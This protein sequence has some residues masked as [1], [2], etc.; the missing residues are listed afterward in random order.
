MNTNM[1]GFRWFS[2]ILL[3]CALNENSLSIGKVKPL[4]LIDDVIQYASCIRH[5]PG[6]LLFAIGMF[7]DCIYRG[8]NIHNTSKGEIHIYGVFTCLNLPIAVCALT[9][10]IDAN[11]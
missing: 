6:C 11:S 5:R 9:A 2:K 1:I 8:K 3:P 10:S 4:P 7:I